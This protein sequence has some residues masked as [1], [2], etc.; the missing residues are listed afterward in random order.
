MCCRVRTNTQDRLNGEKG[1]FILIDEVQ[2][3]TEIQR[4]KGNT[5]QSCQSA[6]GD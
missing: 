6:L 2:K 4:Q 5:I 1:A 3:N